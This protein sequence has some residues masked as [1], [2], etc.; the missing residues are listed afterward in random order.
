M[1][2]RTHESIGRV[3]PGRLNLVITSHPETVLDGAQASCSLDEALE[4]AAA[5]G[6]AEAFVFGGERLY[7]EA[8]PRAQRLILS[9]VHATVDGDVF[10]PAF[11]PDDWTITQQDGPI[12][13]EGDE[14][15]Y[16]IVTYER[17]TRG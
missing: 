4:R 10:F 13:E 2:R 15:P 17:G 11:S 9:H 8:L 6:A 1:G 14:H 3:L 16:T 7:R 5:T 12:Q